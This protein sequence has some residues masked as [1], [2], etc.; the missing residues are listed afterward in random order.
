MKLASVCFARHKRTSA[1]RPLCSDRSVAANIVK[2]QTPWTGL[3]LAWP[4]L[5]APA[6][7][8]VGQSATTAS[9]SCR[10]SPHA[11]GRAYLSTMRPQRPARLPSHTCSR[12]LC[13]AGHRRHRRHRSRQTSTRRVMDFVLAYG[14]RTSLCHLSSPLPAASPTH[15]PQK[16][17]SALDAMASSL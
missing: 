5:V 1:R 3:P 17:G 12:L 8:Q 15:Q 7:Q 2:P 6:V 9:N 10:N 4:R 13:V 14:L 16:R 11:V